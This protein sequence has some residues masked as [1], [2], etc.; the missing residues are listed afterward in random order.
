ML[1]VWGRVYQPA[2][3]GQGR[4]DAPAEYRPDYIWFPVTTD[5]DGDNSSVWLLN[6][7]Q[8]I[9]LCLGESPFYANYGI[10]AQP[11]VV[12]QVYPDIYIQLI[13]QQFAPY[14]ASLLIAKV[15]DTKPH[16]RI[17]ARTLAGQTVSR[18][19]VI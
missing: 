14:F 10:P 7:T 19:V 11:S 15:P 4:S 9:L 13:Q 6:L 18:E 8:V 5:P 3:D 17:T 12:Q 2:I 16:Y 1:R